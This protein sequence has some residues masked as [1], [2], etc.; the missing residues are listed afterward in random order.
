MAAYSQNILGSKMGSARIQVDI[1][2]LVDLYGQGR[3]KLDELV[4]CYVAD[5]PLQRNFVRM[6]VNLCRARGILTVA[7][8]T[9]TVEQMQRL[10]EDGVDLFQGALLGMPRPPADTLAPRTMPKT[11]A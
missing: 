11:L 8:Y 6:V 1:P 9:R 10:A 2:N 5:D 4:T 3:V 7:E